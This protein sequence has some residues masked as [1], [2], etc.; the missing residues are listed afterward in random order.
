[1]NG[2]IRVQQAV[3]YL[4]P[5]LVLQ[6][7]ANGLFPMAESYRD[8]RLYWIDPDWR[9]IFPFGAFHVPRRLAR[10]VRSG[11]FEVRVDTAFAEVIKACATLTPKRHDTWISER[12]VSLYTALHQQGY[13]HS[14]ECWHKKRLAGGLY[15]VALG[16]AFFGESMFAEER[17]TSKVALVHLYERLRAGGFVLFD[18]QFVTPHLSQFGAVEIPRTEYLVRLREALKVD[19]R[20]YPWEEDSARG[21]ELQSITQTS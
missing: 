21:G 2:R 10:T 7:Y 3:S 17:D 4:T 12:I 18:I 5:E 13:A 1:M 15:G 14:V 20:F 19:A 9:A 16:G 8:S 11:K 6:A